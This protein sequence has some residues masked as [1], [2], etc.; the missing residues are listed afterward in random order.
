MPRLIFCATFVQLFLYERE[1]E[2]VR[3]ALY[4]NGFSGIYKQQIMPCHQKTVG[5]NPAG[6]ATSKPLISLSFRGFCF[7]YSA[8]L[9]DFVQLLCNFLAK[10]S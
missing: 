2:K 4:Y 7:L 6:R 10:H 3:K 5:S 9:I 8:L 1:V